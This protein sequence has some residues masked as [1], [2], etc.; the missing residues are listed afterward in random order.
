VVFTRVRNSILGPN[1]IKNCSGDVNDLGG[2]Y[3]DDFS[4]GVSGD[5]SEIILG[6]LADNGGPTETIALLGGDPID[7]AT[8]N[9]DALNEMGNPTGIPIGVDQRYFP[10]P[11]GVR[12]D[13]GAFE[14]SPSATVT[15]TKVTDPSGGSGF[16]FGSDGFN[17]LQECPLSGGGDGIFIM[18]DGD[19]I[20]C[21]VPQGD[22]SIKENIP[23]GYELL[24]ICLEAPDNI[25][26]NNETG[27][28]DFTIVSSESVVD[29]IYTNVRTK[30]G[31]DGGGC[32]LAPA[33]ASNSIPLYLFIPALLLIRRI[34]KKYR[35]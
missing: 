26:I 19:S 15:I 10:R 29:C 34:V 14:D 4:C 8:N 9:C 7:G 17:P 20:S 30:D 11:F 23:Q 12:C 32:T 2:N 1:L 24:I 6:P 21:N 28:I 33:G 27:E 35:S 25:V 31:G 22:Y 5:G 16:R 18:N 3:S 13:S